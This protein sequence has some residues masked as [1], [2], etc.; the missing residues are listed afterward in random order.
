MLLSFVS[1]AALCVIG[2][3]N[4]IE[5]S[6][7]PVEMDSRTPVRVA[8]PDMGP[9]LTHLARHQGHLAGRLDPRRAS[10]H[11][12]ALLKAAIDTSPEDA[13]AY[14]W[15]YDLEHRLGRQDA[16]FDAL[17]RYVGLRPDDDF[18]GI[19]Y[20]EL[21]LEERQTTEAR[22]EF[23]KAQLQ[24]E[25]RSRAL[26]S[27][28]HRWLAH[29]FYE[30]RENESAAREVEQALRLNPLNV[31]ARELAYEMFN[32]TEPDLQRVEM[33]LQLISINP[34]QANLVWDL[35]EFLDQLSLHRRAQAWYTRAIDLHRRA[36]AGPIPAEF[37]HKLAVSYVN[38]KDF[39]QAVKAADKALA[40]APRLHVT[41]LLR[42]HALTKLGH[43]HEAGTDLEDVAKAYASRIEDVKT[44]KNFDEA[45]EIAWFYAYHKP[46]PARALTLS[47]IAMSDAQPSSLAQVAHGFALRLNGRTDEAIQ[48]L[49]P[50]AGS[51]QLAAYELGR[52]QLDRGE[53]VA[54]LTTLSR[55]TELQYSGIA[56]DLICELLVEHGEPLPQPPLHRN[57]I[58]ALDKFQW[59]VL[60]YH[61]RPNEFLQF[62]V[63]FEQN[64]QPAVGPVNVRFRLKNIGPFP[65]TF[66]EGFMARPLIALSAKVGSQ[67]LENH[68]N[69]L[70]V[71]MNSRTML[72]P[73]EVME[74][75]V[76]IDVGPLRDRL[77]RTI[78]EPMPIEIT[79]M[80]DPVYGKEGLV[81]GLGTIRTGPYKTTRLPLDVSTEGITAIL[82][83]AGS[84]DLQ[85]RIVAA[86]QIG[87][88]LASLSA[89]VPARIREAI[90]V[91]RLN[92]A[93]STLLSDHAWQ[94]VAHALCA[95]GWS[96][97]DDRVVMAASQH[98]RKQQPVARLMAIQLFAEQHGDRFKP[99]LEQV[100]QSDPIP[101]IRLMASSYLPPITQAQADYSSD[102]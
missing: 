68:D 14:Y 64:P 53:K 58:A 93:L 11:V 91:D 28:L 75:T 32:A 4:A 27:E 23:V 3:T 55:A 90:P 8:G 65:I 33:A 57:V 48:A 67:V 25:Q 50:L 100:S 83:R 6:R 87:A 94:V 16:A 76:G 59:D 21:G 34:S 45:A 37:Q 49:K 36:D 2:Q 98:V 66:G 88:I 10:L 7:T 15:L 52:L 46:D 97:L 47:E 70:Q 41:R 20:F 44:D 43:T 51:D 17:A 80:F 18:A 78:T 9:W 99:V 89:G 84:P 42:M 101:Y 102:R 69:Y 26:E 77:I 29:H 19:R 85:Q 63:A 54:A 5:T 31:S 74:K 96:P 81:A 82:N 92:A 71:M 60:D 95:S 62:T 24:R 12:M 30:R 13:E 40:V 39:E 73:G 72:L 56:Y 22:T 79:A 1:A 38:S 61:H 35:A 86:Q